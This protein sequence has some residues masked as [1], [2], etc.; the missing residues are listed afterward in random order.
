MFD[1]SQPQASLLLRRRPRPSPHLGGQRPVDL[2]DQPGESATVYGLGKSISRVRSLLQVQRAQELPAKVRQERDAA[3]PF[4]SPSSMRSGW[5]PENH[6]PS[7]L[8]APGEPGGWGTPREATVPLSEGSWHR[9]KRPHSRR[10][11]SQKRPC[12]TCTLRPPALRQRPGL[13]SSPLAI[14]F[15][16]VRASRSVEPSTPSSCQGRG[17]AGESVLPLSRPALPSRLLSPLTLV[18]YLS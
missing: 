4:P 1:G 17:W 11:E 14:I 15:L 16:C 7:V 12:N 5:T 18:R 9:D 10:R 13:T 3:D 8:P 6:N 2:P